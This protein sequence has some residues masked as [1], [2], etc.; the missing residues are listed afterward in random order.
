MAKVCEG[1]KDQANATFF[2]E[3]TGVLIENLQVFLDPHDNLYKDVF[4]PNSTTNDTSVPSPHVGYISLLP[5]IFGYVPEDSE[6]FK[7][8]LD[9]VDYRIPGVIYT[10]F[11]ISSLSRFDSAFQKNSNYW[12]GPIWINFNYLLLRSFKIYYQNNPRVKD[13]YSNIRS[14]ILDT[15]NNN[16]LDRG[17][18]FEH[19]NLTTGLGQGNHPFTGW[20]GLVN[21]ILTEQYY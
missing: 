7:A 10:K 20:S 13:L 17:F 14:A 6:A 5:L 11:G 9:L 3:L 21:F 18:I 4:K 16:F 1:A 19:Y 15:M 2:K 12:T 8:T